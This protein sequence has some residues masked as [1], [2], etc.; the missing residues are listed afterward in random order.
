MLAL[1]S[2][3]NNYDQPEHNLVR[4][5]Q[6]KPS[7]ETVAQALD[8]PFPCQKDE[9]TLA[10]VRLWNGEE[11]RLGNT[12]YRIQEIQFDLP[13]PPRPS[14]LNMPVRRKRKNG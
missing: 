6:F 10:V 9:D 13:M 2:I 7:I 1:F 11:V 8:R 5:W 4:L 3:D 14:E 12:D